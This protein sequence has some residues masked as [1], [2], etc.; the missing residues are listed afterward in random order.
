[1]TFLNVTFFSAT[2]FLIYGIAYFVSSNM[3]T[4]LNSLV[5]KIWPL[6]AVLEL[7]GALNIYIAE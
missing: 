2:S 7:A 4:N 1:M 5:L 6:T 3:K